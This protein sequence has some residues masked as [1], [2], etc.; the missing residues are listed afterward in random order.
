MK[1]I[2]ERIMAEAAARVKAKREASGQSTERLDSFG[3][4]SL[5]AV[6]DNQRIQKNAKSEEAAAAAEALRN[7]DVTAR[8]VDADAEANPRQTDMAAATQRALEV[9][10]SFP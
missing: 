2:K 6:L 7:T 10:I 8:K 3:I 1:A 4:K 5:N 9:N